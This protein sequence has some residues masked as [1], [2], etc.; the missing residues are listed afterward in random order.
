MSES[1]QS[2]ESEQEREVGGHGEMTAGWTGD[3]AFI[4]GTAGGG[5]GSGRT[6]ASMMY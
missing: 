2:C 6:G 3:T 5:A 4:G 1:S